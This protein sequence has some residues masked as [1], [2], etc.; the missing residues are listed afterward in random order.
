[1]T[2]LIVGPGEI[3]E[4]L[5]VHPATVS[6]WINDGTLPA[7]DWE[8]HCGKLWLRARIELFAKQR[9]LRSLSYVHD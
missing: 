3:V 4:M 9:E 1:M 5:G 7:A 8:L 6:R 2:T